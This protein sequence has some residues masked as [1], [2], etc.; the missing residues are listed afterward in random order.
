MRRVFWSLAFTKK[1]LKAGPP[2]VWA[3]VEGRASFD[4]LLLPSAA[5][6]APRAPQEKPVNSSFASEDM[7]CFW[8]AGRRSRG[9]AGVNNLGRLF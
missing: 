3:V 7:A 2:H 1:G 4:A 5:K 9:P 6:R 8:A